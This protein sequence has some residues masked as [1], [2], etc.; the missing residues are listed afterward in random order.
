MNPTIFTRRTSLVRFSLL[1]AL[2]MASLVSAAPPK[3]KI[4]I[5]GG[6]YLNDAMLDSGLLTQEFTVETDIGTSPVLHYGEIEGVPFYYVHMHGGFETYLQGW[7]AFYDLGVKEAIGGATAGSVNKAMKTMDFIVPDDFIDF[8]V[9]RPR[10]FPPEVIDEEGFILARYVPAMDPLLREVVF[11][12]TLSVIRSYDAFDEINVFPSG[13]I[14]QAVGGRFETAAEI[15]HF[16]QLGGDLVT[17]NI[18][19]EVAYARQ[20]GINYACLAII[21]NPA[22]GIAPWEFDSLTDIYVALNPVSLEIIKKVIPKISGLP[23]KGRVGESL[24]IHPP[25]AKEVK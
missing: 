17:M 16:A 25:M 12:E 13:T 21:S 1:I 22:E 14:V 5:I 8:N 6:T 3:A 18:G 2:S 7:A 19:T 24:R 4:A 10:Y 23:E 11:Q 15:R 20:L 9:Q